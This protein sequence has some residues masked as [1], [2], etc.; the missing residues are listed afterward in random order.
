MP[1]PLSTKGQ[2]VLLVPERRKLKITPGERL[3]V[4]QRDDGVF[5][6]PLHRAAGYELKPHPVSSLPRMVASTRPTRK[7]TVAEIARLNVELL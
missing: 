6:R 1:P 5:L 3:P 2:F 4:D 7:V